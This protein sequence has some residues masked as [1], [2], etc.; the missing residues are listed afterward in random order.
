MLNQLRERLA[1]GLLK[2]SERVA[3]SAASH[4]ASPQDPLQDFQDDALDAELPTI[5]PT[6]ISERVTN[7]TLRSLKVEAF[8]ALGALH[9]AHLA[10]EVVWDG[11]RVQ[12][13]AN[14][15]NGSKAATPGTLQEIG[16]LAKQWAIDQV[17]LANALGQLHHIDV[18][19]A[20]L[21]DQLAPD[22][23]EAEVVDAALAKCET[24]TTRMLLED[25]THNY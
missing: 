9:A 13:L 8:T 21:L 5:E 12:A 1:L 25:A 2:A 11:R 3:P 4:A 10:A 7:R 18:A 20:P 14:Q 24:E 17:V 16:Q 6:A 22:E 15:Q 23:T 19:D